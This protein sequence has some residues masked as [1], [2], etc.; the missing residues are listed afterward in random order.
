LAAA[1]REM[2]GAGEARSLLMVHWLDRYLHP[3][4]EAVQFMG[5]HASNYFVAIIDGV[6]GQV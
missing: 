2:P 5:G 1:E 6:A 3:L 4:L